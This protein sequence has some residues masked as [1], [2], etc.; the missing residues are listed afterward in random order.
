MAKIFIFILFIFVAFTKIIMKVPF[1]KFWS[2]N[3][4]EQMNGR[5]KL[6][7]WLLDLL[8]THHKMHMGRADL[9]GA[10]CLPDKPANYYYIVLELLFEILLSFITRW[11]KKI[12]QIFFLYTEVFLLFYFLTLENLYQ[13][14]PSSRTV[15]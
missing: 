3:T 11:R 13:L 9:A 10:Y 4:Y 5:L 8:S 12:W 7:C 15:H 6:P 1:T 2:L 14:G